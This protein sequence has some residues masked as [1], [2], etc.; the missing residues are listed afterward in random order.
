MDVLAKLDEARAAT[1]VLEHPFYERWSAGALG[2]AELSLYAAQYRH[3]VLALAEASAQAA[4]LSGD[5]HRGPLRRHAV[6]EAAHVALWDQFARAAHAHARARVRQHDGDEGE[7]D[8][9]GDRAGLGND[10]RA[11][12]QTRRCVSAW[13]DGEDL[14]EH[15]AVLYVIEASQPQI[16]ST[17]LTGLI[18]HY[19]YQPEGP[20]VEYFRLHER[21]DVEH[22]RQARE[23]IETL[24]AH[25]LDVPA[26]E[27]RMLARAQQALRGNWELLSG[28]EAVVHGNTR[29]V[30]AQT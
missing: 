11:L 24:L 27:A 20:A 28:V 8:E 2:S 13:T 4:A 17:K 30:A 7:G 14:L 22:A 16:A 26:A 25:C 29:P 6:E 9:A 10:D 1:N 15:V 23:L 3:A 21:L 19:G 12:E 5:E 18:E